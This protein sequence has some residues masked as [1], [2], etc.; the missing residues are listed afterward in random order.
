MKALKEVPVCGLKAVSALYQRRPEAI[1]RLFFD[2]KTG[3][4]AGEISRYL[5]GNKKIYRQVGPEELAKVAGT[6]HHG[7][8][9][10][11]A[12]PVPIQ[13]V[14]PEY[15]SAWAKNRAQLLLLDRIGNTHNLGA[16]VRTAAFFGVGTLVM[17]EHPEQAFPAESTYRVAEGGMEFVQIHRVRDLSGLCRDLRG[18]GFRVVGASL[19]GKDLG[20]GVS[21]H[22]PVAVAL[23]NEESGLSAEV[24]SAC[25]V[26]LKVPGAGTLE[27]LNVSAAAAIF[28]HE[29]FGAKK[30]EKSRQPPG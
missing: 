29:F 25:D 11:V 27:S 21:Y 1:R 30:Q 15:L 9:V 8:I 28:M 13:V 18:A 20:R 23:G 17:P 2:A 10:A 3:R 22:G 6:I 16:I 26:L 7:G 14:T 4:M 24:A 5:A 19:Q 12:D